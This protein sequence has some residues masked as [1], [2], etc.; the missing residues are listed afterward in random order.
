L[1]EQFVQ[2]TR[3]IQPLNEFLN[4]L[5][6]RFHTLEAIGSE[7][8]KKQNTYA[9]VGAETQYNCFF[10]KKPNHSI[11][12]CNEFLKKTPA[13]RFSSRLEAMVLPHIVADQ[14]VTDTISNDN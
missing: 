10:C 7:K 1:Y 11:Y 3:Q 6:Q 13:E 2:N 9:S 4:F 12:K 8:G 14:Q 5:E